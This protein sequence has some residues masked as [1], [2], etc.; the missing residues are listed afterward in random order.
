M[1][2][3]SARFAVVRSCIL[4]VH[5]KQIALAYPE[6][7]SPES[8]LMGVTNRRSQT[9]PQQRVDVPVELALHVP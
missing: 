7:R 5:P 1:A 9:A 3:V 8:S 4:P 6:I 2:V